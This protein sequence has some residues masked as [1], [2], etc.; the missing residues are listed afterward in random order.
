[1]ANL[2]LRLSTVDPDEGAE[3]T[4]GPE[5]I[6]DEGATRA[7]AT[8]AVVAGFGLE[9]GAETVSDDKSGSA[10]LEDWLGAGDVGGAIDGVL[11]EGRSNL[12]EPRSAWEEEAFFKS[13]RKR[14]IEAIGFPTAFVSWL[15]WP[16]AAETPEPAPPALM[17]DPP[18][19]EE[20][21]D[22]DAADDP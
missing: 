22:D 1:L 8:E 5:G 11:R 3:A 7:E 9:L 2:S 15:C 21:E 6:W 4:D 18:D 13:S 10:K 14:E 19:N 16:L 12:E 20:E 17:E